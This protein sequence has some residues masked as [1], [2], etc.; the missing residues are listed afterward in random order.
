MAG[1]NY[2]KQ[3]YHDYEKLTEK[4]EAL[5]DELKKQTAERKLNWEDVQRLTKQVDQKDKVNDALQK[6]KEDLTKQVE[7]L[8]KEVARL[9]QIHDIDSTNSG[10]PT[11]Q[12][13]IQKKKHVP[14]SRTKSKK[15]KGGQPGH[16]KHTL[17]Q[18]DEQ[19]VNAWEEHEVLECPHCL[20]TVEKIA[21][22]K[23]KD[24]L[25]YEVVLVKKRHQF[26]LYQCTD[27]HKKTQ[28]PVP[29]R[30]K[31]ANQY[32]SHVQAMAL[33]FMNEGN[34]SINKTQ[35]MIK[36]FT[37]SEIV[38]SEGYIAK[39]QQ[40]G[41]KIL[42]P[43]SEEMRKYLL[44]QQLIHW[45]DTVIMVNQHRACLRF[46]GDEQLALYKAHRKKNKEGVL[47]D[48]LLT[49]LHETTT[50]MHD[51]LTM[52]YGEEFSYTNAEC[53]VHLLRDLRSCAENTQ[54]R[55]A[56]ELGQLISD[57]HKNRKQRM[58]DGEDHFSFLETSAFFIKLDECWLLGD[59]E[60]KKDSHL[61]DAKKERA[62]LNRLMKYRLAYF[63][64]VLNFDV[65]FSNNT[66]ERSLRG[67]KSKM[68]IAGQFQ[69]ILSAQNYATIRTY[70]ETCKRHGLNVVDALERAVEGNPYTLKEVLAH[71]K[72]R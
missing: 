50:V 1:G 39:L 71:A 31:E 72:N 12:T 57:T 68:K 62:L 66:S 64:W 7:A 48:Q 46:Y 67:V 47:E 65:P 38:P 60:N 18:F 5:V 63:Y 36:G 4:Y 21:E 30:L 6:E 37:F 24:E 14:N 15:K 35:E 20:G 25:D 52:N 42:T 69:T 49:L 33:T 59:E 10:V 28:T 43:F 8:K 51:H 19:E 40:R 9:H 61:Y 2:H 13:P 34:V 3:L 41:A 53:N 58:A 17:P 44:S 23:T 32:G 11:S 45:D 54:H 70:V 16:K 55:W 56:E 29:P 26:P 27:C 22:G